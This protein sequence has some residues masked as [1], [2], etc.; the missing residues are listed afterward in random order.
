LPLGLGARTPRAAELRALELRCLEVLAPK[1]LARFRI[2][3]GKISARLCAFRSRWQPRSIRENRQFPH[4]L[5][6]TFSAHPRR[7]QE[8]PRWSDPE[9]PSPRSCGIS[10]RTPPR[11]RKSSDERDRFTARGILAQEKIKTPIVHGTALASKAGQ[12][13][14]VRALVANSLF[15]RAR[16]GKP[17]A[18]P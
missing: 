16:A 14:R 11:P 13:M 9:V 17:G 12:I 5:G 7:K 18:V 15:S 2:E 8:T 3:I 10:H 6:F 1:C 4:F